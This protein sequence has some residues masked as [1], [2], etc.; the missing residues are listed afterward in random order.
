MISSNVKIL[1]RFLGYLVPPQIFN[2]SREKQTVKI[3]ESL[4]GSETDLVLVYFQ[5]DHGVDWLVCLSY[6]LYHIKG[7]QD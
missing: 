2:A 6:Q 5:Q 3:E 7:P 4:K 1:P